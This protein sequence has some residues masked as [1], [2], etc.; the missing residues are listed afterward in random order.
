ME[1]DRS[2]TDNSITE[3]AEFPQHHAAADNVAFEGD[4]G[5]AQV[6]K[7]NHPTSP[8][9][10]VSIS[11]PENTQTAQ[12]DEEAV[13]VSVEGPAAGASS[14]VTARNSSPGE[15]NPFQGENN[16]VKFYSNSSSN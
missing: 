6:E 7:Q 12:P 2:V 8:E 4:Q 11:I 15:I 5:P 1:L 10:S 16:M 3:M 13:V 14:K 9:S